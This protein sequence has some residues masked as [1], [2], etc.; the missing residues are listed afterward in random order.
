MDNLFTKER[1]FAV[2]FLLTAFPLFAQK[3]NKKLYTDGYIIRFADTIPCK[4]FYGFESDEIG[5]EVT[6]HYGDGKAITYHPGGV[7]KGFGIHY[8]EGTVHYY[9]I[10][11]PEYWIKEQTNNKAYAE[12]VSHGQLTLYEFTKVKNSRVVVP[13]IVGPV[14]GAITTDKDVNH[15]FLKVAGEDSMR[16]LV[17]KTAF[18]KEYF[19]RE[20]ILAL[21]KDRPQVLANTPADKYIY[22]KEL[23]IILN[24]YNAWHR[25]K[26]EEELKNTLEQC[27]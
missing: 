17:R 3:K 27:P 24:N 25:K 21:V 15:Y 4:I 8:T 26:K 5:Y 12:V 11:V 13:I 19:E 20:D 1:F 6:F 18:G 9:Q 16:T 10:P 22:I 7:V 23:R 14:I 2:V